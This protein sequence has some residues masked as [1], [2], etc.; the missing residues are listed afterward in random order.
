VQSLLLL[1]LLLVLLLLLTTRGK[2]KCN[3]V[4]LLPAAA[5]CCGCCGF[6]YCCCQGALP[7]MGRG[8][9][10][11]CLACCC[12]LDFAKCDCCDKLGKGEAADDDGDDNSS[13][14]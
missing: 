4:S 1:L 12:H 8:Q 14:N 5:A 10:D 13:S 11:E 6:C 7:V 3:M 9:D 2:G